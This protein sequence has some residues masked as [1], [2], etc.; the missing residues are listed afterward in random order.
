MM[1]YVFPSVPV[2]RA[3]EFTPV[4]DIDIALLASI[5]G[6]EVR[7]A[8]AVDAVLRSLRRRG[9][10]RTR[11]AVAKRVAFLA[12]EGVLARRQVRHRWLLR[13]APGVRVR[14]PH[15]VLPHRVPRPGRASDALRAHWRTV[16]GDLLR[17]FLESLPEVTLDGIVLPGRV[18]PHTPYTGGEVPSPIPFDLDPLRACLARHVPPDEDPEGPWS[19]FKRGAYRYWDARRALEREAEA[20]LGADDWRV[21]DTF[22]PGTVTAG[23]IRLAVGMAQLAAEGSSGWR[24]FVK[25]GTS[26]PAEGLGIVGEGRGGWTFS[27]FGATVFVGEGDREEFT[28]RARETWAAVTRWAGQVGSSQAR[29][30]GL[31]RRNLIRS[32]AEVVRR[33]QRCLLR[34]EPIGGC[35]LA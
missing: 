13:R 11:R 24:E 12:S 31:H 3:R 26:E 16:R 23:G 29:N 35:D 7:Q 33:V 20:L 19:D 8:D 2:A 14:L 18:T 27:V 30:L 1:P 15:A 21:E 6:D 4:D 9:V 28:V 34:E 22:R 25:D 17:P 32:R 10:T 5:S